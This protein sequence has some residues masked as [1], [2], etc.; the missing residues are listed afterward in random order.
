MDTLQAALT[1]S[2]GGGGGMNADPGLTCLAML[3]RLHASP[4]DPGAATP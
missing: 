2:Q 1:G 3:A 4:A